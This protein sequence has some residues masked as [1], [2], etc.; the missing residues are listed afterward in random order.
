MQSI[1]YE[2]S[3]PFGF[4]VEG[5]VKEITL[6]CPRGKDLRKVNIDIGLDNKT[7]PVDYDKIMTV[8]RAC[9]SEPTYPE[10][11]SMPDL[12]GAYQEI[13]GNFIFPS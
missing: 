5:E 10:L 1:V 9:V 6:N 4:G 11:M 3:V 12:L 7:M 13:Y 8:I 2:L